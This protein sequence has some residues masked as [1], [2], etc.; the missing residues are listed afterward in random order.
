MSDPASLTELG[1]AGLF[2]AAFLAG[3]VLPVSSEPVLVGVLSL[4]VSSGWAVTVATIG[5]VLGA[6]T[7]YAMGRM[8]AARKQH[9]RGVTDRLLTRFTSEDPARLNR[10]RERLG[11]WGPIALLAAWIPVLGDALVLGAGLLELPLVPVTIYS[12][13]GKAARYLVVAAAFSALPSG[14]SPQQMR[15]TSLRRSAR[16]PRLVSWSPGLELTGP[17]LRSDA[18]EASDDAESVGATDV[19]PTSAPE[20]VTPPSEPTVEGPCDAGPPAEPTG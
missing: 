7:L 1:L 4:G 15:S 18:V 2:F 10:A 5:N 12:T 6:L 13:I 16:I 14:A 20:S 19:A 9:G 11:R 3:S 8:V 17:R